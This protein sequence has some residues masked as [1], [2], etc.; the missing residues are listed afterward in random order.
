MAIAG[1]KVLMEAAK[2]TYEA[3]EAIDVIE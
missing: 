1:L 2:K 3:S